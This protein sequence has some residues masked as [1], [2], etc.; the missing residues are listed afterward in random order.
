M[1][2]IFSV[3]DAGTNYISSSMVSR[4]GRFSCAGSIFIHHA[5]N[6]VSERNAKEKWKLGDMRSKRDVIAHHKQANDEMTAMDAVS[7]IFATI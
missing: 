2:F 5:F 1:F 7:V 6:M 4:F 3:A